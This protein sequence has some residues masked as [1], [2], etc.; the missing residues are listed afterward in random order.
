MRYL[1]RHNTNRRLLRGKGIVFDQYENIEVQSTGTL[2]VPKGTTSER[3][4]LPVVG[5]LRYNTT[6]KNFEVYEDVG[7]GGT[8]WKSFRLSE[9]FGITVQSL[10][11]GNDIEINFGALDS[12]DGGMKQ[13][14]TTA[15]AVLVMIENVLQIPTTNY[16]LVQ[17]PCSYASSYIKVVQNYNATGVGAF[18][19]KD[20][21]FVDWVAGGYHIGQDIVVTGAG[22]QNNNGTWTV[23]AIT[24]EYLSVDQLLTND[25]NIGN[26]VYSVAGQS[27]I[28][29]SAY[30]TGFY[31]TFGTP[32]PTGKPITVLH[33]FDK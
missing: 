24:Q 7:G 29:S 33:N 15:Q 11:N 8:M 32:V 10:G 31:L 16:M 6:T 12:N 23:T 14:P 21:G 18:Q 25:T 26:A 3:P 27:T 30:P 5:Q 9:P 19:S 1:K 4:P 2:Q 17:N 22:V 20:L 28:T 13:E